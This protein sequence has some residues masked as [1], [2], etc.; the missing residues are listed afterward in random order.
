MDKFRS[1]LQTLIAASQKVTTC[2]ASFAESNRELAQTI[3]GMIPTRSESDLVVEGMRRYCETFL[4]ISEM[5]QQLMDQMQTMFV[6]PLQSFAD[7]DFKELKGLKKKV[8]TARKEY[9]TA[10]GKYNKVAKAKWQAQAEHMVFDAKIGFKQASLDYIMK[11]NDAEAKKKTRFIDRVNWLVD[12]N[13]NFYEEAQ[14]RMAEMRAVSRELSWDVARATRALDEEQRDAKFRHEAMQTERVSMDNAVKTPAIRSPVSALKQGYLFKQ[15][16][17]MMKD[18]K[19]RWFE[20]RNGMFFYSNGK[21]SQPKYV[22]NLLFAV[23]KPVSEP[24]I[25]CFEVMSS[26]SQKTLILQAESEADRD[27]WLA[28]MQTTTADLLNACAPSPAKPPASPAIGTSSAH[29]IDGMQPLFTVR[30]V[31]SN[32]MCADCDATDPEWAS[33]NLGVCICL[34][35]SGVHRALGTHISKVRSLTLDGWDEHWLQLMTL[36]G[37]ELV[38][39]IY[40]ADL[41]E[42]ARVSASSDDSTHSTVDMSPDEWKKPKPNS[43]RAYKDA[44][45]RAKYESRVFVSPT[46]LDMLELTQKLCEAARAN[47][48]ISMIR[49]FAAGAPLSVAVSQGLTPLHLAAQN[50]HIVVV[51]FLALNGAELNARDTELRTPLMTAAATGNIG[52]LNALLTAKA[53]LGLR[54]INGHS[55]L[56]I[57]RNAGA[58]V[59]VAALE[60]AEQ[61]LLMRASPQIVPQARISFDSAGFGIGT[62]MASPSVPTTADGYLAPMNAAQAMTSKRAS[63]HRRNISSFF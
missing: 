61:I 10:M 54:D 21:D 59:C 40:E 48:V 32:R 55:A 38:N 30:A 29:M 51:V 39:S 19:R 41:P 60:R 35:C 31:L 13:A 24:R 49:L 1:Q 25:N 53:E 26:V 6:N 23:A 2:G 37:N 7:N 28:A 44:F 33:A 8:T 9:D 16:H 56:D 5:Q 3:V 11:L 20:I 36:T 15:T 34:E 18:W 62:A 14:T 63:G 52:V 45:I 57:A 50:D 47:D 12:S 27:E 4:R 22:I 17:S 58:E 46:S 42:M 43:S